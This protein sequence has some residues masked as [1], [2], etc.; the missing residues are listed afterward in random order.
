MSRTLFN[1]IFVQ[2]F[3]VFCMTSVVLAGIMTFGGLLRPLTENGLDLAQVGQVFIYA[4]PGM[5]TYSLPVAALF[6]TTIV[7]GRLAADNEVTAVRA[8]G[9]SLGPLG[10]G[11]PALVMGLIV[12]LASVASLSYVV[13]AAS[14]QVE[15]TV[16][17]N[18]GQFVVN[19][20]QQQ[21]KVAI[22]Q[23]GG[24]EP[25][26][27]YA[28][29]AYL[30]PV[31]PEDPNLQEVVLDNV[32][33]VNYEKVA[34]KDKKALNSPSSFYIARQA[35]AM[36]RQFDDVNG[37]ERPP[38]LSVML[39]HGMMFP[40]SLIGKNV[41]P[42]QGGIKL[43][44]FGPIELLS[45]VRENTKFMDVSRLKELGIHP[46]KSN[47]IRESLRD[48]ARHEQER[49][50]LDMLQAQITSGLGVI[51]FTSLIGTEYTLVPGGA[52][53]VRDSKTLIFT[54]P[55]PQQN[56]VRLIQSRKD[57][58]S[59]EDIAR[60]ARITCYPVLGDNYVSVKIQLF[61]IT[62]RGADFES[63]KENVDRSFSVKMP[64]EVV[65]IA[66]QSVETYQMTED[67]PEQVSKLRRNLMKQKN[68]V[69]SELHSRVSFALSCLV[70]TV[71]GYGLGVMF[72]SGNYLTAFA[73]SVVPALLSIMLIVTGQHICENVPSDIGPNFKDPRDLGLAVIWLGNL[74]VLSIAVG[75]IVK[76]RR[77]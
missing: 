67:M 60:E 36:I 42:T 71:V 25:M 55:S 7:Y 49:K 58:P 76:L 52:T 8:A 65:A 72:K 4:W 48:L 32:A 6:A 15:K 12:A 34:A 44:S 46:E 38:L 28:R 16:V 20:V 62:V 66:N 5:S 31:N 26:T 3:K 18:I 63:E 45:P 75:L 1:Y 73:V 10:F 37:E 41:S 19:R 68:S 59:I 14:L 40:R 39:E 77:T 2:L 17:S 21:H 47:K 13:P 43:S 70:L 50:Y 35:T 57:S 51:K 9:I 30:R 56:T 24:K 22:P 27:I 33:I 54:S 61:D 64:D 11:M 29:D 53:P 23:A 69:D 74:I